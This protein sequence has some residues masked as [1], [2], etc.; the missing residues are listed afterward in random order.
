M[1]KFRFRIEDAKGSLL[2]EGTG[3]FLDRKHAKDVLLEREE[4]R[5]GAKH[6]EQVGVSVSEVKSGG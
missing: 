2:R 3:L 5:G 1:P 4:R 6:A